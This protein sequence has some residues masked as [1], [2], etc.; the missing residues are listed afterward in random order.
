MTAA[1]HRAVF[2]ELLQSLRLHLAPGRAVRVLY[3]LYKNT[4]PGMLYELWTK[5]KVTAAVC[6][7]SF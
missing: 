4:S 5:T 7:F 6:I 1:E 2:G 3:L